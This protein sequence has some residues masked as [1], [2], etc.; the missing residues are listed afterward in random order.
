MPTSPPTSPPTV[1]PPWTPSMSKSL[2]SLATFWRRLGNSEDRFES[3]VRY[4]SSPI[5]STGSIP[6]ESWTCH[7]Y[8][9][10]G[11]RSQ[12]FDGTHSNRVGIFLTDLTFLSLYS[13]SLRG[14]NSALDRPCYIAGVVWNFL[15]THTQEEPFQQNWALFQSWLHHIWLLTNSL[16]GPISSKFVSLSSLTHLISSHLIS[17][18]LISSHLQAWYGCLIS[19]TSLVWLYIWAAI[20]WKGPIPSELGS[21]VQGLTRKGI[22]LTGVIPSQIGCLASGRRIVVKSKSFP[23]WIP[24]TKSVRFCICIPNQWEGLLQQQPRKTDGS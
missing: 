18:H 11:F 19:S 13:D 22:E 10:S 24:L 5:E 21:L 4:L 16:N 7:K 9:I 23:Y 20:N 17:S 8:D 14:S 1:A 15:S 2:N 3:V 12:Y 6:T